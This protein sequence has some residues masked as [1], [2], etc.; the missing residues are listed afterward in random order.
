MQMYSTNTMSAVTN[1]YV[2]LVSICVLAPQVKRITMNKSTKPCS[3]FLFQQMHV[4]IGGIRDA[5]TKAILSF[6]MHALTPW[7]RISL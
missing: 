6:W 4:E 2:L 5:Y 7:K 1:I 3:V